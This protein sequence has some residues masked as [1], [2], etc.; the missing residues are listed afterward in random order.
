MKLLIKELKE[1]LALLDQHILLDFEALVAPNPMDYRG[2]KETAKLS[3]LI[4][5]EPTE[6]IVGF[7]DTFPHALP[8]FFYKEGFFG[9]FPHLE[10]DGLICFTRNESLILDSRYPA[11]ILINCLEKVIDLM[12]KGL[13][14]ENKEDYLLEFEAYWRNG[15][16]MKIYS[17][18]DTQN[19]TVRHLDLWLK[20]IGGNYSIFASEENENLSFAIENIFQTDRTGSVNCRCIYFPLEKNTF[21]MPPIKDTEWSHATIKQNIMGNLSSENQKVFRSL[22]Q[23][24]SKKFNTKFDFVIIGLPTSNGNVVLF[25]YA[26]YDNEFSIKGSAKKIPFHPFI[27]RCKNLKKIKATISRW[28]PSHMLN[29][30]GGNT[31]LMNKHVLIVGAGSIGSEIAVRFAK[32]GV[33]KISLVDHDIMELENVH[34]HALGSNRVFQLSEGRGLLHQFKVHALAEEI[35]QKYP[36][37]TVKEYAKNFSDCLKEELFDWSKVD[38]V[39]VSIGMPNQEMQ[40]NRH[41]LRLQDSPPVLYTWV[42]PLG[43]GGH[44]LVTANQVKQGCYQCL[45]KPEEDDPIYNRSAFAEPFQEFSKAVTGC[46]SVFTPYNFLDSERTAILTA[47]TGIKVLTQ[48]IIDNPLLSW[49]GDGQTFLSQG[50][51]STSRYA[52]TEEELHASRLM[53]KDLECPVCSF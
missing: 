25:S 15:A 49:K 44:V 28:H 30:T 8:S 16:E 14:G 41:M 46:G 33:E 2:L 1:E 13:Y 20:E 45:F 5:G 10:E 40:I 22:V 51:H 52:L 18:I 21:F 19:Q 17:C 53:Y 36:F 37:T 32:A 11:S 42:E 6:I 27:L 31:T 38:L 34:R 3:V 47:A 39:V 50:F 23:K 24:K 9:S 4:D 35:Q 48:E 43:I 12:E 29:R 7:P 26:F